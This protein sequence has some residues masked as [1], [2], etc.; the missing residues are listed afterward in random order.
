MTE[1]VEPKVFEYI[2]GDDRHTLSAMKIGQIPKFTRIIRPI[3][4]EV[5]GKNLD[6]NTILD[7][8]AD[9]GES[10]IEAVAV[11]TNLPINTVQL[12]DPDDFVDIVFLVIEVNADFFAKRLAPMMQSIPERM[13]AST[14]T[15]GSIQSKD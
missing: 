7:L 8:I 11:A 3:V 14:E 13:Q 10:I 5:S 2:L 6:Q 9:H 12:I 1:A 15:I 4:P